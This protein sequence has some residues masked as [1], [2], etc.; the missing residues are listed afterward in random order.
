MTPEIYNIANQYQNDTFD[1]IEFVIEN[2]VTNIGI[3]L[4][5]CE[6]FIQFRGG[7]E[8]S[9]LVKTLTN[10]NKGIEN[11]DLPNGVFRI[12]PFLVVWKPDTYAYDIQITFPDGVVKTFIKGTVTVIDDTSRNG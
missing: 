4:T 2:E 6:I 3:D 12:S 11:T 7:Y 8:K 9:E 10:N 1:G 5:G